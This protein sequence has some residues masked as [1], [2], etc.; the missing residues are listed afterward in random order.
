MSDRQRGFSL[1][2]VILAIGL[3]TFAMLVIF[4]VLPV[5]Y[6]S[7]Q[8]SSRQIVETEIFNMVGAELDSTA[9]SQLTNYQGT[10]FPIYLD[11]EGEEQS[12]ASNA[13]F[14]VR[15]GSPVADANPELSRVTVAI[16]FHQDP[17]ATNSSAKSSKRTFL[18]VNRGSVE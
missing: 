14:I 18:L 10:R 1:V 9:R 8:D 15:C 6:A 7:L 5:G 16:G 17:G 3:I 13:V 12:A 11:S 4:S 2:E